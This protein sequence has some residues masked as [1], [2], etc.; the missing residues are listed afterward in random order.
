LLPLKY[1]SQDIRGVLW[2]GL[3]TTCF[4][5]IAM[6]ACYLQRRGTSLASSQVAFFQVAIP[7]VGLLVYHLWSG[8]ALTLLTRAP[9]WALIRSG[10]ASLAFLGWFCALRVYP[11]SIAISFRLLGPL[12]TF[13][14]ALV[15]LRER[16]TIARLLGLMIL[17]IGAPILIRQEVWQT[18]IH[19]GA[20]PSQLIILPIMVVFGYAC[21]N[22]AGKK[23]MKHVSPQEATFS[24]LG[25]NSLVIGI[26]A[27]F[28]WHAPRLDEW[29]WLL[30]IG[31]LEWVAQWSL[32]RA[33][34]L[35]DLNMLAPLSLWRF[36]IS[37]LFGVLFLDEHISM[38]FIAGMILMVGATPLI[39]LKNPSKKSKA[40]NQAM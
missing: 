11:L 2:K 21:A 34:F 38:T 13:V 32:A 35:T 22:L 19:H 33:L 39:V 31:L 15:L 29:P 27:A 40:D 1:T 14:A 4:A 6:I 23:L 17:L 36:G 16:T 3:S 30:G 26:V 8:G 20:D 5:M 12:V 28:M 10:A 7:F 25:L 9:K 18:Q 24:L 37:A